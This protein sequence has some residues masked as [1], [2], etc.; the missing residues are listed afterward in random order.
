MLVNSQSCITTWCE[1]MDVEPSR[2]A[3]AEAMVLVPSSRT[4]RMSTAPPALKN[5]VN[6]AANSPA[7]MRFMASGAAGPPSESLLFHKK[8]K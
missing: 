8:Y 6:E 7:V 3:V 5:G 2:A 1:A 4:V